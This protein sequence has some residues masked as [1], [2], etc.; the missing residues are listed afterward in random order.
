MPI[1]AVTI[2]L[3]AVGFACALAQ[4]PTSKTVPTPDY[5]AATSD[6]PAA[7]PGKENNAPSSKA[8]ARVNEAKSADTK[9]EARAKDKDK[10]NDAKAKRALALRL[11]KRSHGVNQELSLEERVGELCEQVGVAGRLDPKLA[12]E[13]ANELLELS[14][15]MPDRSAFS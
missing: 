14:S 2:G 8:P 9:A 11:L 3:V 13:W 4:T 12:N 6:K 10:E 1:R 7:Q 5:S 15:Q